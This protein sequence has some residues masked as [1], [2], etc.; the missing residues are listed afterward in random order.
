MKYI[1][2]H[3]WGFKGRK[4]HKP[5]KFNTTNRIEVSGLHFVVKNA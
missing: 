1:P 4:I 3:L 5:K 2:E